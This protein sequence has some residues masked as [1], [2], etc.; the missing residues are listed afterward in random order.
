MF[1]FNRNKVIL[2]EIKSNKDKKSSE[3]AKIIEKKYPKEFSNWKLESIRKRVNNIRIKSNLNNNIKDEIT[4]NLEKIDS[5][6][7]SGNNAVRETI[8]SEKVTSLDDLIRVCKIDTKIWNIDKHEISAYQSHTKLRR[9]ANIKE[10]H[11]RID[12]EHKVVPLFRVKAYL[13]RK[14]K[15]IQL[16]SLK[17]DIIEEMKQY[18][19]KYPKIE[20]KFDEK[21][22]GY[23]LEVALMDLHY[24][25]MVW[26]QESGY[27]Y[28]IKIASQL[29]IS[30]I[31]KILVQ[32]KGYNI[33]EILFTVGNDFFN[34]DTIGNTTTAG[35]P[36]DEDTRWKKTFKKG[37]ELL[38]EGINLLSQ[39]AP[40]NVLV[41]PGNHD[42]QRS[43]FV[44]DA[45]EC[46]FNN[47]KQVNV[48]NS[49]KVR[50]Y[51]KFGK[52]MILL[53]HGRDE[54]MA[55]YP[56]LMASEEPIMWAETKFKEVH[57]GEI[58][59]KKEISFLSTEE[60]KG[61]TVRYMRSLSA[62]S[63]WAYTKGFV[64]SLRAGE[65]FIWDEE[66]GLIAQFTANI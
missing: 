31:N 11:T 49:P 3:I 44:G 64:S 1:T 9:F 10:E 29:F 56:L 42:S 58:H 54:K 46:W 4:T 16:R 26:G 32:S 27:D 20:Y 38:I 13:S 43:F 55:D 12:D 61:V 51:Y 23:L 24:G 39:V 6:I 17:D 60:Y 22:K 45:L 2:D 48:N 33:R 28:D 30:A 47:S 36:Q 8:T 15:E 65:A 52:C 66:N 14:V 7:E 37:R 5:Y 50:K 40:V 62:P 59:H 53:A 34:V 19:P 25:L 57:L 41:I 18:S 21:S 63:N 35:T